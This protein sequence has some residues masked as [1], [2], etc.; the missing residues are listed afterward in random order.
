MHAKTIVLK[1]GNSARQYLF[2][3][4]F[5]ALSAGG[6]PGV[7]PPRLA[8]STARWQK[9]EGPLSVFVTYGTAA[10]EALPFVQALQVTC[11]VADS[12]G[13]NCYS[14]CKI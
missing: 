10:S 12:P 6:M 1:L 2:Y 7:P 8:S 5:S 14:H 13:P 11:T 4:L 3:S 9:V